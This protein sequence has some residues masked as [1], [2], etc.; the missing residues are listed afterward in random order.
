MQ[1]LVKPT[2]DPQPYGSSNAVDACRAS[3]RERRSAV[4]GAP[5]IEQRGTFTRTRPAKGSAMAEI[6]EVIC[7]CGGFQARGTID[8]IVP[9]TQE[10]GA[11]VHN[12]QASA[13]QVLAMSTLVTDLLMD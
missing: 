2:L 10:H 6:R 11:T 7:A 5:S 8:E 12:M 3:K 4:R 9:L 13:Q 1:S